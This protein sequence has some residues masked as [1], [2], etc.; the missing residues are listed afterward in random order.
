MNSYIKCPVCSRNY[1]KVG[2]ANHII[3]SA[4]AELYEYY[5]MRSNNIQHL[6]Y[7]SANT[8]TRKIKRLKLK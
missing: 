6:N 1:R 2:I 5:F 3:N 8:E 7:C 4:K